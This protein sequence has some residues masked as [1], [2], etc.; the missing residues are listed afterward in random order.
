MFDQDVDLVEFINIEEVH[1]RRHRNI[2]GI[3]E[4]EAQELAF[5][6]HDADNQKTCT[7]D[8]HP[9]TQGRR[10]PKEFPG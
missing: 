1:R 3:I 10:L 8:S 7:G 2:G 4:V 6:F 5:G 9:S